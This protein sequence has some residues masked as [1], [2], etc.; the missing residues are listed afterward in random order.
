M[1]RPA[2]NTKYKEIF[3]IYDLDKK[4]NYLAKIAELDSIYPV[5]STYFCIVNTATQKYDYI[6]KNFTACTGY[7]KELIE[8]GGVPYFVSL[9][10]PEDIPIWIKILDELMT[11]TLGKFKTKEDRNKISYT[12]NFRIKT[13][14]GKYV[15]VIQNTTPLSFDKQ[16]KPYIGLSHY[17]LLDSPSKMDICATAKYLNGKNKLETVYFKNFTTELI[18]DSVSNREQDIIRLLLLKKSSKEIASCLFI[19]TY[20]VNTHRRNIL[21]KFNIQSTGELI[22]YFKNNPELL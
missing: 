13:H 14:E 4:E 21:K 19:S 22:S 6:S 16:N 18:L 10:H 7:D 2:I 11:F 17:T 3:Q 12:W 5:D 1:N 20:T 9:F 8:N 15:N